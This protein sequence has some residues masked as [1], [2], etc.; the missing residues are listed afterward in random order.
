MSFANG[1]KATPASL[2]ALAAALGVLRMPATFDEIAAFTITE[3]WE[4]PGP[5]NA[6]TALAQDFGI[7]G[8][9][10]KEFMEK[11]G[12][13]FGVDLTDFDWMVY[14]G[15]EGSNPNPLS[16]VQYLWNRLIRRIAA[17]DLTGLPELTLG[18]LMEC[19]N[20]GK[21]KPPQEYA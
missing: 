10:G 2:C 15:K 13:H 17:R 19:A 20:S 8:L 14:F 6:K 5:V 11:Y 1:A 18:H 9:D 21:W 12:A 3:L 4:I 7:A 16:I